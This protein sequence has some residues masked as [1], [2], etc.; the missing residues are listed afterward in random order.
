MKQKLVFLVT[1]L[2]MVSLSLVAQE[3]NQSKPKAP[4][5]DQRVEK[6]AADLGLSDT[7]KSGLKSL[8]VKQAEEMKA[9]R[10]ET[11]K[12]SDAFKAKMKELRKSQ[13][14]EL[15]ALIGDEKYAKLLKIR[16]EQRKK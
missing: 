11:D 5:L 16:A 7:E 1:L 13:E 15:K 2:C 9:L 6:M 3:Q 12:E 4:G 8:L 10:T 14:S